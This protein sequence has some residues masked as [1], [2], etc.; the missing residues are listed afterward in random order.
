M[1]S[2]GV[3]VGTKFQWGRGVRPEVDWSL[4]RNYEEI[5]SVF[6]L[7]TFGRSLFT[8]FCLEGGILV[9]SELPRS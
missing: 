8:E 5:G 6:L 2:I 1:L 4:E 7:I 9:L 3:M